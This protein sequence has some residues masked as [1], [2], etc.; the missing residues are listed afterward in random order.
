L[1]TVFI[2][3]AARGAEPAPPTRLHRAPVLERLLT[4]GSM[5]RITTDWRAVA[6]GVIA[7]DAQPA[8]AVAAASLFA[9]HGAVPAAWAC[10][11]TPVHLVAGMSD[12]T[13]APDGILTLEP[14]EATAL[15]DDFNDVFAAS[16]TRLWT[17]PRG[18]LLCSFERPLEV[19][20]CEPDAAVDGD[21]LA[22]QPKGPDA[23]RL[24][25]LMSEMEMWLFEH[26]ANRLRSSTGRAVITGLWLWGGGA[27]V[28]ALPAVRGWTA[29]E[30][31]LFAVFG[32][33]RE[34][35]GTAT[36]GVLVCADH[37]ASSVW[38]GVER[39]WLTPI[40][41]ALRAQRIECIQLSYADRLVVLDRAGRRRF[42]KRA[43]PWWDLIGA[44][45]AR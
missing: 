5:A 29:G 35:P 21:V 18:R 25:K 7:A 16:G 40:E 9:C 12:V 14:A 10:I 28:T 13:L 11:A 43:R 39:R 45:D 15:A 2:R 44:G 30:D 36:P 38:P 4:R 31:P 3:L 17:G 42:W 8:P 32:D 26:A 37:P 24:R 19:S 1:S 33:A 20:A 34:Y 41:A 6:F 27:T 23:T 22:C